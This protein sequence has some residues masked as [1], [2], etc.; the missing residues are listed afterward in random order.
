MN[1]VSNP[2][3]ILRLADAEETLQKNIKEFTV[4]ALLG[5]IMGAII[6]FYCCGVLSLVELGLI[7]LIY[8]IVVGILFVVITKYSRISIVGFLLLVAVLLGVSFFFLSG[9]RSA[10]IYTNDKRIEANRLMLE[11]IKSLNEFNKREV[12]YLAVKMK[13]VEVKIDGVEKLL[14]HIDDKKCS[15]CKKTILAKGE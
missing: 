3:E 14:H 12:T 8:S 6:S 10:Q 1:L 4:A 15:T 5:S 13:E 2:L 9:I 11:T 7:S